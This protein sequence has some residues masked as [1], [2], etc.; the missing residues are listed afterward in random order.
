MDS[1]FP[2]LLNE[3]IVLIINEGHVEYI[4]NFFS[5]DSA[6][7]FSL[8]LFRKIPWESD[9]I[10][11]FGKEIITKRK[12]AWFGSKPFKYT[13][14]KNTKTALP[15]T[16]ELLQIKELIENK[17]G[18][19]FNSCLLNLY[20]DGSEAMG[21]HTDNEKELKK[22]GTI[23]S[24]SFGATRKFSL[25][26]RVKKEIVS[27]QLENGSLLLMKG[28]TQIH[29]V[30]RLHPSKKVTDVRINLTFRMMID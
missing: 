21:W 8:Q 3:P 19:E 17:T 29:W 1:L 13:Y 15:W 9:K 24:V 28:E 23:A 25:K 26:H 6:N 14:S 7:E 18:E 30:H 16:K 22:N 4:P 10:K 12:V 20:H 5:I 2:N 11:L 27:V